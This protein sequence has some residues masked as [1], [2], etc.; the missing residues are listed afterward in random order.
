MVSVLE[1][2]IETELPR[3]RPIRVSQMLDHMVWDY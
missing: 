3:T 2:V 1:Q